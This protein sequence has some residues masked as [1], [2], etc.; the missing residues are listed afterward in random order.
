MKATTF[1]I[2][3][4]KNA[5]YLAEHP[6]ICQ[7]WMP[8]RRP[9]TEI[10]VTKRDQVLK[11]ILCCHKNVMQEPSPPQAPTYVSDPGLRRLVP[12]MSYSLNSLEGVIMGL[13]R[14]AP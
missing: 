14:G 7:G 9:E 8:A 11:Y 13:C 5:A 10:E 4:R 2:T 12:Q 1:L 3:L 6:Q